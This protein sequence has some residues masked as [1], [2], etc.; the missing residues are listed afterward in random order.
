MALRAFTDQ[1]APLAAQLV[2]LKA[3][4]GSHSPSLLTIREELP[5]LEITVDACFISNP[6]ATQL[7]SLIHISEPTRPY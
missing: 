7:L 5:D 4:A 1:E 6:Y 3:A 2:A